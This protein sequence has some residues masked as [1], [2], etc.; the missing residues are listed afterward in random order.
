M[1]SFRY[2]DHPEASHLTYLGL[3]A[4]STEGR[5]RGVLPKERFYRHLGMGLVAGFSESDLE[6]LRGDKLSDMRY[7]TTG[8]ALCQCATDILEYR[9][10]WVAVAH[11]G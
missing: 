5:K 9:G 4:C 2:A 3:Y 8:S 7:S 10:N 6:K 11:N 1:W